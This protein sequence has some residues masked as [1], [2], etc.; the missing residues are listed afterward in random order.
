MRRPPTVF[1]VFIP[2]PFNLSSQHIAFF[3]HRFDL[4]R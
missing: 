2:N 3:H 1:F 4:D